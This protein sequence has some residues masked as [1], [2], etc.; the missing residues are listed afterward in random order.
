M[1][2][3]EIAL[4]GTGLGRQDKDNF[5]CSVHTCSA[6]QIY[7][8]LM[9]GAMDLSSIPS[10]RSSSTSSLYTT[11]SSSTQ[12][13]PGALAGKAIH[14]LGKA[15]V[16]GA[17]YLIISRRMSAIQATMPCV[18]GDIVLSQ[19][20]VKMFDDVLELS[21]YSPMRRPALYPESHRTQAMEILLVQIATK[22]THHVRL[23]ILKLG[24]PH[25]DLVALLS[26][27]C[28]VAI[29]WKRGF[30]NPNLV[31]AYLT[32]LPNDSHPWSPCIEF[33]A[34]VAQLN[35][36]AF[37]AVLDARFFEILLWVSGSQ[38]HLQPK[39]YDE[40]LASECN[41]AFII[42]LS[43]HPSCDLSLLGINQVL[44]VGPNEPSMSL[45]RYLSDASTPSRSAMRNFLRCIGIGGNVHDETVSV[46]SHL[47]YHK[48][49]VALTHMLR[50]VAQ[51]CG[52][53]ESG[54]LLTPGN[55]HIAF[56]IIRFLVGLSQADQSLRDALLDAALFNISP[57]LA[58]RWDTSAVY[59]DIY[60]RMH[61]GSGRKTRPPYRAHTV[62]LL[63]EIKTSGVRAV[64]EQA[65]ES[66]NWLHFLEPLFSRFQR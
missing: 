33:I 25:T 31:R 56:N 45:P 23:S 48:K 44:R 65:N 24:V 35:A 12:W 38:I 39:K 46:L 62:E 64:I 57:L 11:T 28:A 41:N 49:V 40:T 9:P 7:A 63:G 16:R 32:A 1:P 10:R 21:R 3:I 26:E 52:D 60:R 59:G 36:A 17:E 19:N 18:D 22:Q 13:G 58:T 55:P 2:Q 27:I 14:A 34:G 5:N 30:S 61:V 6:L 37:H 53:R 50:V 51:S 15:V 4:L 66:G 20:L 43:Q 42:V 8:S 54:A 47:S 29:F